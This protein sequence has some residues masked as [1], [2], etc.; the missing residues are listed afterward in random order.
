MLRTLPL[1]EMDEV[2][3][4][5]HPAFSTWLDHHDYGD[6]WRATAVDEHFERFTMPVLQVCGW[7]DLY[8]GGMMAN[9]IGLRR[10]GRAAS[11]P[12]TNQRIIMGPWTHRQAGNSPPGTTNAGDRDFGAVRCST[13]ARSSW[14]GSTTG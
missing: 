3:G 11:W 7:Y 13:R 14:P 5:R 6:Y 9:F 1:R 8:A 4:K 10:T 12:A 2:S